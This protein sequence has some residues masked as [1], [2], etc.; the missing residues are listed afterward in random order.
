MYLTLNQ[1]AKAVKKS[2]STI[3]KYIKD[4]KLSVSEKTEDGSFRI[5][6]AELYRVFPEQH[7]NSKVE[8]SRIGIQTPSNAREVELLEKMNTQQSNMIDD[9]QKQLK[10]ERDERQKI[11]MMLLEHQIK[12]EKTPAIVSV[13]EPVDQAKKRWWQR[14]KVKEL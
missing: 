1:A 8:Q 4:G 9:L 11:T 5:D 3:S 13:E 6:P 12:H 2:T 7:K 10:E 14:Q